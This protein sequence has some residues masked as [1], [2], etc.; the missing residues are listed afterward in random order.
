MFRI[1]SFTDVLKIYCIHQIEL[2]KNKIMRNTVILLLMFIGISSIS[3]QENNFKKVGVIYEL[4]DSIYQNHLGMNNFEKSYPMEDSMNVIIEGL[5]DKQLRRVSGLDVHK[6][7]FSLEEINNM[8]KKDSMG[9][10]SSFDMIMV[11]VDK[12]M[13]S[14]QGYMVIH[15]KGRGVITGLTTRVQVYADL[16]VELINLST[17]KRRD[18]DFKN[19]LSVL[20]LPSTAIAIVK[21]EFFSPGENKKELSNEKLID[22]QKTLLDMYRLQIDNIFDAR[23]LARKINVL[24]KEKRK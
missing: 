1:A 18:Y 2:L 15:Y 14:A 12:G 9:P 10:I 4:S 20:N 6:L 8:I 3:G 24:F 7:E 19:Y 23:L 5:L 16:G 22:I 17:N 11:I 21:K 13:T